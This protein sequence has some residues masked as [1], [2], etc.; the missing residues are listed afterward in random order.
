MA[1]G[2]DI[3]GAR[4]TSGMHGGISAGEQT[5]EPSQRFDN[6]E[7]SDNA[8]LHMGN[9]YTTNVENPAT[10]FDSVPTTLP[11]APVHSEFVDAYA[12]SQR[13]ARLDHLIRRGANIDHRDK[14]QGTPLHHA[15][16]AGHLS[17]VW[18]LL[19]AGADIDTAGDWVV[20]LASAKGHLTVVELL[21]THG[22]NPNRC[23][24]YC[25]YGHSYGVCSWLS[26]CS[27]AVISLRSYAQ[28]AGCWLRA[29]LSKLYPTSPQVSV[30]L[31][32]VQSDTEH[33]IGY[34]VR[35]TGGLGCLDWA[36]RHS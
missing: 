12:E 3:L 36:C 17:T 2:P 4:R 16:F 29:H 5:N 23:S 9:T 7:P 35:L 19:D 34:L 26:G 24:K 27:F 28:C 15:A 22:A 8:R 21:L 32:C 10:L 1:T 20:R 30:E 31:S 14:M 25:R 33:Q 11:D 6:I 18:Y 13:Q